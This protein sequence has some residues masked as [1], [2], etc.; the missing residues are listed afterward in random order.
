MK[1]QLW[2]LLV[3]FVAVTFL[4]GACAPSEV[5]APEDVGE[6]EAE[7]PADDAEEAEEAEAPA[8][9]LSICF[10][11]NTTINDQGWSFAHNN[12]RL[13]LEENLEGITT[14]YVDEVY[15]TGGVDAA[16]VYQDLATQGC[17]AIFGTSFG[18]NDA[19]IEVAEKNPDVIFHNYDQYKMADNVGSYRLLADEGLYLTGI[20]AGMATEVDV[21]GVVGTFPI[22]QLVR[23]VNGFALGVRAANP[24][25]TVKVVWLNSWYDPPRAKEAAE[26]LISAGADVIQQFTTSAAA[27]QAAEEAGVYA[28]GYQVDQMEF[29]PN[30]LLT[31]ML[32]HWG[33]VYMD[34]TEKIL[35]GSWE[36][37]EFWYGL[38]DGAVGVGPYGPEVTDEMKAAVDEASAAIVS[39]DLHVFAG[40]IYDQEGTLKVPEG[41][42]LTY[43][44]LLVM[45]W[46][47]QGIEG[48]LTE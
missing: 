16:K 14:S 48:S 41:E 20:L 33:P 42:S 40:P 30:Y 13:Y 9:D 39:G 36:S 18:Y 28:L 47:V 29:A 11:N 6:T 43:A 7:A 27:V 24:D 17:Q 21:V 10:V 1:K 25:A 19:I 5:T 8:E 32:Y 12:G 34:L 22:P 45:D 37:E 23:E 4:V 15:D 31:S 38:A 26:G 46:M 3:I 35:S 44:D 2:T